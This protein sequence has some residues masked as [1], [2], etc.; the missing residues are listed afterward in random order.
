MFQSKV[1]DHWWRGCINLYDCLFI[2]V[3]TYLFC[4]C[5]SFP[6]FSLVF[7]FVFSEDW[8]LSGVRFF[9]NRCWHSMALISHS[10]SWATQRRISLHLDTHV[11]SFKENLAKI[12]LCL[13]ELWSVKLCH[14]EPW[15]SLFLRG[16]LKSLK[17]VSGEP[18]AFLTILGI[19]KCLSY[20]GLVLNL[21]DGSSTGSLSILGW[22]KSSFRIFL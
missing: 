8:Q 3:I 18:G 14:I 5:K 9:P 22:P 16:W 20:N 21:T 19:G 12:H 17:G 2:K 11:G 1:L 15:S 6:N 4:C 7:R 10:L 13:L